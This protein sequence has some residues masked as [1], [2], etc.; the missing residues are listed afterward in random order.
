MGHLKRDPQQTL[1]MNSDWDKQT[2]PY[3]SLKLEQILSWSQAV[4]DT[5]NTIQ[6]IW[7][8]EITAKDGYIPT[9]R[10]HSF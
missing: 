8:K 6:E 1:V 5:K 4:K 3:L 10:I 7:N 9:N 2:I